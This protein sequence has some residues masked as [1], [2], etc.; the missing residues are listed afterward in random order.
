MAERRMFSKSV[1]ESARFLKMP[2]SSQ[3]LYFHLGMNADDDGIVEAYPVINMIKAQEDDLKVLFSKEFVKVLNQD[4]VTYIA[5]WREQNRIRPDR[6]KDSIYR[7]LLLQI[8]PDVQLLEKKERSDRKKRPGPSM[9][10]DLSAQCS[11][12]EYS[13]GKGSKSEC[14]GPEGHTQNIKYRLDYEI[15][16]QKEYEELIMVYPEE[17]VRGVIKR[18]L[19]KPYHGCLNPGT[20]SAWCKEQTEKTVGNP[21]DFPET[22]VHSNRL[23]ALAEERP[24]DQS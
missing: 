15:L 10:G 19:G 14:A 18:I 20:I 3:N 1:V 12:V 24:G 5:D 17:I 2:P 11:V 22:S 13:T 23:K 9:D 6:K 4:L 8:K 21:K 16:T 7:D